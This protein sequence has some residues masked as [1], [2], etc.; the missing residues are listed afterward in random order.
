MLVL[1]QTGWQIVTG[2]ALDTFSSGLP[3]AMLA[4]GIFLS[5]RILDFADLGAEGS[6]TLG[7]AVTA[8]LVYSG[9]NPFIALLFASV[10]GFF[11]G[12]VTGLLCTK[13]K[14]PALL[15]GI[16][17]MTALFT[18][19]LVIMGIYKAQTSSQPF[20]ILT[21]NTNYITTSI[22]NRFYYSLYA[23]FNST[24]GLSWF[25]PL[26]SAILLL[27]VITV[28]VMIIVYYFYGTEI[29]MGVRATGMNGV[30]ARAQGIDTDNM[31][32]LGLA[33]SNALISLGGGLSSQVSGS[34][35]SNMGV[36]VLVIGLA[37]I[38]I[39][40]AIV[41]RKTFKRNLIAVVVGAIIYYMIISTVINTGLLE[42]H[43]LKLLYA[44]LIVVVLVISHIKKNKKQVIGG[45][46]L[47][48]D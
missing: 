48:R 41:G 37:S 7:G 42:P 34:T 12:S 2:I 23:F 46:G 39:G 20:N 17:T 14:I 40:E 6:F 8:V 4:L 9:V 13:L 1:A 43:Y 31:T 29:G 44:V 10:A 16:I 36:G 47:A 28:A 15:S 35:S 5:Y 22:G 21:S 30:M 25:K 32:I 11:A 38:I 26:Y 33:I 24:L 3:Y 18:I 19:N 27:I 45:N